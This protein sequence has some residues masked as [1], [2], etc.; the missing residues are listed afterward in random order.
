MCHQ[1]N[2]EQGSE[3]WPEPV[4]VK[5]VKPLAYSETLCTAALGL[6]FD[7]RQNQVFPRVHVWDW[8]ADLV[9]VTKASRMYEVEVKISMSDWKADVKKDKWNSRHWQKI[10]RFYYAVSEPLL[11]RGWPDGKYVTP[12]FVPPWAGVLCMKL[13]HGRVEIKEVRKPKNLGGQEVLPSVLHRLYRSTYFRFW[14]TGKHRP[15]DVGC[16][17]CRDSGN[18]LQ[19]QDEQVNNS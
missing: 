8:E 14:Q 18:Q 1:K 19:K 7:Y 2:N 17:D 4:V 15:E 16:V 13:V 5:F 9:I 11:A 6:Y 12:D 3:P 10:S